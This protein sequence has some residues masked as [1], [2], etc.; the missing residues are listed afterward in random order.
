MAVAFTYLVLTSGLQNGWRK[1]NDFIYYI[2]AFCIDPVLDRDLSVPPGSE[3]DR[4]LYVVKAPGSG[5]WANQNNNLAQWKNGGYVFYEPT[6][7]LTKYV[8]DETTNVQ[9]NGSAWV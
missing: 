2:H 8:S 6:T 1:F 5:A 3:S 4:D 9:W 7:G